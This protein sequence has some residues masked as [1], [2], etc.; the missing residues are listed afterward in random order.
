MPRQASL[1]KGLSRSPK[2]RVRFCCA[3]SEKAPARLAKN[4][5]H[6]LTSAAGNVY[7]CPKCTMEKGLPAPMPP[8]PRARRKKK[9]EAKNA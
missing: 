4:G 2:R 1:L 9:E 3:C 7:L 8:K 5:W 6:S